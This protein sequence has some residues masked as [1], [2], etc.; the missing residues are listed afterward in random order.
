MN[1]S[2]GSLSGETDLGRAGMAEPMHKTSTPKKARLDFLREGDPN[3]TESEI[4][5]T[6]GVRSEES[7]L[8]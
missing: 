4:P 5:N 1:F 6:D 2:S 3:F 8:R 7:L